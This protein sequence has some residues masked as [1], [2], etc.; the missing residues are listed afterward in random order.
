MGATH[1]KLERTQS[2]PKVATTVRPATT[3]KFSLAAAEQNTIEEK[4]RGLA[5]LH[6]SRTSIETLLETSCDSLRINF[7][8]GNKISKTSRHTAKQATSIKLLSLHSRE[9]IKDSWKVVQRWSEMTGNSAGMFIFERIFHECPQLR[10]VFH[11]AEDEI[12]G[13]VDEM[14]P[15][16]R[17]AKV[18]TN[19]IDLTVSA[20]LLL[21]IEDSFLG[22][23][24]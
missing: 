17:H 16:L 21:N 7:P 12:L 18:F 15:F 3:H 5:G 11:V 22:P 20:F 14:H 23:I 6:N 4:R 8:S 2:V 1:G 24:S 10:P 13:L 19:M 9:L